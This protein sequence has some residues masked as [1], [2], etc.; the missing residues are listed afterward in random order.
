MATLGSFPLH[1]LHA[2]HR[3]AINEIMY[4]PVSPEPEWIELFNPD[5]SLRL[6]MTGWRLQVGS[7]T[8]TLP[9]SLLAAGRFVV[10]TKDSAKLRQL[11]PGAYAL[12]QLALPTLRNTGDAIVFTDSTSVLNDSVPYQPAWGGKSGHS[13]ERIDASKPGWDKTNWSTSS[14]STGATPGAPNGVNSSGVPPLAM[15]INEVMF[16]PIKP[17]PEWIEILNTTKDTLD[18]GGWQILVG[19]DS[20][21]SI[22]VSSLLVPPDSLMILTVSDSVLAEASGVS[23]SRIIPVPLGSLSNSGSQIAL[24]DLRGNTID[25]MSY[26]G[27]WIPNNG[28]SIERIDPIRPG[29]DA[30]NWKAC[31]DASR[32]TILRPNSVR[33][34]PHDLAVVNV[35]TTDSTITA[36]I[37]NVGRDSAR[38]SPLVVIRE[39]LDTLAV[40]VKRIPPRDSIRS[41]IPMSPSFFGMIDALVFLA[42]P[43]D[44]RHTNDTIRTTVSI[45]IPADSL[46]INEI[47][48]EPLPGSCEWIELYNPSSRSIAINSLTLETGQAVL[49]SFNVSDTL[50]ILPRSF[51]LLAADSILFAANPALRNSTGIVLFGTTTLQLSNDSSNSILRNAD[52]TIID[53]VNYHSS[54]HTTPQTDRTGISLERVAW[55]KASNDPRN[56]KSSS[57]P[58]GATPLAMNSTGRFADTNRSGIF[59]ASFSPNPFSP[60]GDGFEDESTLTIESGEDLSYAIRVRLYDTHGRIVRTLADAGTFFRGSEVLFDGKNDRGQMLAPGLYTALIELSSQNPIRL[61]SKVI[62]VAIA[63]K[64]K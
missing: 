51:A 15:V 31:E 13:L 14:S 61:L 63:G 52:M 18:I 38:A 17:E 34:L 37:I 53:S 7:K 59:A 50:L 23:R 56:W 27:S 25:S 16:A 41:S 29:Y 30:S 35:E 20:P 57:D 4:A 21:K 33:I 8:V 10:L 48:V 44:E 12:V 1:F 11:R 24:Q 40:I 46:I 28:I 36:T 26:D 55:N 64:R 47:M 49:H 43:L 6:D 32:S 58:S 39:G 2:Q 5:S 19:H 3:V 54:W 42:D 9:K 22:P 62:G 60:D 45:D